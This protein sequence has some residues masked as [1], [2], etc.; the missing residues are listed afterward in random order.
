MA[1]PL[2]TPITPVP[3]IQLPNPH[4]RKPSLSSTVAQCDSMRNSVAEGIP[5][6]PKIPA[7]H[8]SML[9][10]EVEVIGEAV[11]SYSPI[12]PPTYAPSPSVAAQKYTPQKSSKP[13]AS[14]PPQKSNDSGYHSTTPASSKSPVVP[15]RSMFPVYNPQVNLAQQQ[16]YP[17][18]PGAVRSSSLLNKTTSP[19]RPR[20]AATWTQMVGSPLAAPSFANLPLD[21]LTPLVSNARE[22]NNLW[23]ATHGMEPNPR[24]TSYD[25]ELTR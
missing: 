24:I 16:Y 10:A 21:T 5:E 20:S 13:D 15:F 11:S 4:Y 3:L 6:I 19:D 8:R 22:L 14:S 9:S 25:L 23:E 2:I 12:D 7:Q 1:T 17:Q 18:R